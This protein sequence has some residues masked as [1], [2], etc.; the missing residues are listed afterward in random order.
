MGHLQEP[1]RVLHSPL[2]VL[3][4]SETITLATHAVIR[5]MGFSH[6]KCKVGKS[7]LS[8]AFLRNANAQ[9]NVAKTTCMLEWM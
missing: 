8:F 7:S 1:L 6:H 5:A 3:A 2:T 9:S 4:G